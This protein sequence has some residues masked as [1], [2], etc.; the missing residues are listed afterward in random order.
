[1]KEENFKLSIQLCIDL[2]TMF[3][4]G[5]AKICDGCLQCEGIDPACDHY[6]SIMHEWRAPS[7]P[8]LL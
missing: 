2:V 5:G 1:M 3:E 4:G 6:V 8:D 7:Y